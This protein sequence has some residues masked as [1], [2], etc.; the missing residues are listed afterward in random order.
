MGLPLRQSECCAPDV[1]N[2]AN[3]VES[4]AMEVPESPVPVNPAKN[5]I[6]KLIVKKTIRQRCWFRPGP[7][8]LV[9][10]SIAPG[11]VG[12]QI[13]LTGMPTQVRTEP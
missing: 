10:S 2:V 13:E 8:E 7:E 6:K 1:S 11:A 3:T 4:P 5:A 9:S 12:N